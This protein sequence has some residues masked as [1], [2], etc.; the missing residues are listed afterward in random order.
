[1]SYQVSVSAACSEPYLGPSLAQTCPGS[2]F[3]T[4]MTLL[5]TF[6]RA[7]D[8]ISQL[9]ER[10]RPID[11]AGDNY[12]FIVI[13]GEYEPLGL[14]PV[15]DRGVGEAGSCA[16]SAREISERLDV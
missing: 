7:K 12:D 9:C 1:M 15:R 6:V 10:V 2:Q 13:G 16:T 3:L 8:E 4:F 14:V 5:D 11:P